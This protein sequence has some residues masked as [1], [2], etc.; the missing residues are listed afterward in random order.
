VG[1]SKRVAD[2]GS[3]AATSDFDISD[4]TPCAQ[5]APHPAAMQSLNMCMAKD[6][7]QP[8]TDGGRDTF[9][10]QTGVQNMA[11]CECGCGSEA[12]SE[13]LPGHDQRLRAAL[14]RQVGGVLEL[15]ALVKAS[16]AYARGDTSDQTFTQ[17]IR[18]IFAKVNA[19]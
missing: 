19:V 14:E 10:H 18:A 12:A 11:Q 3:R 7:P 2:H 4:V 8:F 5:Q 17:A 16:A 1:T 6:I 15:R 13:F 9:V